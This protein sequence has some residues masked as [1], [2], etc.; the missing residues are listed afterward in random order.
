MGLSAK[1]LGASNMRK[2]K[3]RNTNI[4]RKQMINEKS[5]EQIGD[6]MNTVD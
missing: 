6:L 3:I 4:Y 1:M 2:Y 5:I